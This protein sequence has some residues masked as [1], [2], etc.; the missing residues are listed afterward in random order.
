MIE[1]TDARRRAT[2]GRRLLA[3]HRRLARHYGPLGWWPAESAFEV[4]V[5]AILTQNTAWRNA[6]AALAVLRDRRLLEPPALGRLG[7]RRLALLLRPAGTYNVKA[8]RLLAFVA[9]L[10]REFGGRA[11]AM[12]AEQPE[13]LRTRLLSVPGI[14]AETADAIALYA[15]G[16]ASFV[17]DAYTQRI[18]R[19]LGL[20]R[21]DESAET[22]RE[23]LMEQLPRDARLYN[24]YHAQLVAL[25]KD[26]C[27]VRPR[28]G[29]C[30]LARLCPR[31]GVTVR[32]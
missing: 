21:G 5:G 30:P 24:E 19:R 7:A 25:A 10:D 17:V 15:A 12:A 16:H 6:E 13:R 20:L 2:P 11:E 29:G 3:V 23:L 31:I 1:R 27:R 18:L 28:C 9:F 32:G 22:V 4:C 8:R 26:H 14:G